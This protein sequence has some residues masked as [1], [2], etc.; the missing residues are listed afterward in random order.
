MRTG[1]AFAILLSLLAGCGGKAEAPNPEGIYLT[2][3]GLRYVEIIGAS[4]HRFHLVDRWLPRFAFQEENSPNALLRDG[5]LRVRF[6]RW[7]PEKGRGFW[8]RCVGL[9]CRLVGGTPSKGTGFSDGWNET[10][11]VLQPS[12]SIPGDWD[13]VRY[14]SRYDEESGENLS[15]ENIPKVEKPL[16]SFLHRIDDRN[17]LAYF[18]MG[19]GSE[20][21]NRLE[22][23]RA[24]VEAHDEDPYLQT[25]YWDALVSV[26]EIETLTREWEVWRSR[27]LESDN[28]FLPYIHRMV[29]LAIEAERL[30]AEGRNAFGLTQRLFGDQTDLAT[31]LARFPDLLNYKAWRPRAGSLIFPSGGKFL[32]I[33][34]AL[35]VNRIETVFLL[36]RGRRAEA[37]DL[38][39]SSYHLGW[40]IE[41]AGTGIC[42]VLGTGFRDIATEGLL[43]YALNACETA[44]DLEGFWKQIEPLR[45]RAQENRT[46]ADDIIR[47]PMPDTAIGN[48]NREVPWPLDDR[49][50]R[51]EADAR[52]QLMRMAAAARH[53]LLKEGAFPQASDQFGPLLPDGPPPDPFSDEPLKYRS[54]GDEFVCYSVGPDGKDDA[55]GIEYHFFSAAGSAGDIS[56]R[57]PRERK[58]AF[59]RAGVRAVS[60]H[61]LRRIFP[62]GLPPDPFA[63]ER[64]TPLA[65][66]DGPPVMVFGRGP[67]TDEGWL[68]E[69]E[70]GE[71][72][73]IPYDP[74]NG[75]TS[76]GDFFLALPE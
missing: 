70:G 33:Q 51:L 21:K 48:K 18:E 34:I 8:D 9:F 19:G 63:A 1:L 27:F 32:D 4:G 49:K 67:D 56:V 37:L 60:A 10:F 35:K 12:A 73:L 5:C 3:G 69:T 25:F 13:L 55:G 26:G 15:I 17:A 71:A 45:R 40:L 50:A 16:R 42:L 20:A 2:E 52:L 29:G 6:V 22:M 39:K 75:V 24:L 47:S 57:V 31:R 53:H 14:A 59:P 72:L 43:L 68:G 64:S 11:F 36:L 28:P 65:V 54:S 58:Y 23:A 76:Q 66:T 62:N 7:K 30:S 38:L 44:E 61:D 46:D 41:N 74:T